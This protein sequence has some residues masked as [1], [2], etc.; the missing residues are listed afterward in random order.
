MVTKNIDHI[1]TTTTYQESNISKRPQIIVLSYLSKFF[2][3]RLLVPEYCINKLKQNHVIQ[4]CDY[5]LSNGETIHF[6]TKPIY[7]ILTTS[8]ESLHCQECS[9]ESK[10]NEIFSIDIVV[11][12]EHGRGKLRSVCKFILRYINT[13][14]LNSYVTKNAHINCEND[15][16]DILKE[17]IVK[18]LNDEMKIIMNEDMFIF[19]CGIKIKNLLQIF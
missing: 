3:T 16:K 4:Q 13:K 5:F 14:N 6:W 9:N 11:G 18:L 2:G 12:G 17:S 15:T 10:S 8:L 1:T 7:K 19:L